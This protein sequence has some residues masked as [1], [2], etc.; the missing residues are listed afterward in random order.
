MLA[1]EANAFDLDTTWGVTETRGGAN[2][3]WGTACPG[4]NCDDFAWGT[5]RGHNIVWG[6]ARAGNI[7][8]GTAGQANIVWGT[9][10]GDDTV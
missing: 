3:A 4:D 2:I 5:A 1:P 6:T 9:A 8:W 7:V 10:D